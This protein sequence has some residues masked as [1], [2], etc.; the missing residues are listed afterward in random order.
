VRLLHDQTIV[1][2]GPMLPFNTYSSSPYALSCSMVCPS[3]F[4]KYLY[5]SKLAVQLTSGSTWFAKSAT[6]FVP[7]IRLTTTRVIW[8]QDLENLWNRLS[9]QVV[10]AG[11]EAG[12]GYHVLLY[13]YNVLQRM[14]NIVTGLLPPSDR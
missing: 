4:C 7:A 1:G 6:G 14:I 5:P 11:C 8:K 2:Y 9:L 10:M 12:V 13:S 3:W